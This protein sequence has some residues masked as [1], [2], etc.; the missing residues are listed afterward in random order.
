MCHLGK[1]KVLGFACLI[2]FALPTCLPA[3]SF[4]KQ[5]NKA[6]TRLLGIGLRNSESQETQL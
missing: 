2:F 4:N 5:M 1:W 6:L 3:M